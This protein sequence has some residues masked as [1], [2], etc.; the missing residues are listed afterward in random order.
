MRRSKSETHE[1][2]Q[3][4]LKVARTQFTEKGYA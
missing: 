4:L 2:I 1:T 3:R